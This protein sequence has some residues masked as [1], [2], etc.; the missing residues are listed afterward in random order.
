MHKFYIF[1]TLFLLACLFLSLFLAGPSF[2]QPPAT[3]LTPAPQSCDPEYYRTL[4]A[5]AWKEA[6]REISQNQNLIFKPDSVLEY[7]CFN[8]FAGHVHSETYRIFSG[9]GGNSL[10]FLN[11]AIGKPFVSYLISNFGHSNL[12]GRAPTGDSS[13][14]NQSVIESD[15]YA[16]ET[17]NLVW[18]QAKCSNFG[19]NEETDGFYP[20]QTL[21]EVDEDGKVA[22]KILGAYV[23]TE[24]DGKP[25]DASN[26]LPAD[27]RQTPTPRCEYV[28]RYLEQ[29]TVLYESDDQIDNV[30]QNLVKD[31]FG[32]PNTSGF[33]GGVLSPD[34]ACNA[35]SAILTGVTVISSSAGFAPYEDGICMTPG[36]TYKRQ[37]DAG[38]CTR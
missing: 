28:S 17:M 20:L 34:T 16:C 19:A 38:I 8:K 25:I 5:R 13:D 32:N 11:Q 3:K 35:H 6:Q 30:V 12:G 1:K 24:E 36:C 26:S 7:T 2:A 18:Q 14:G 4:Q 37:G 33:S 21:Y 23:R 27:I 9:Q 22:P 31:L 15:D 29:Q 10:G